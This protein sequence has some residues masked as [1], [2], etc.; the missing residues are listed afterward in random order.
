MSSSPGPSATGDSSDLSAT[1]SSAS[2]GTVTSPSA[3]ITSTAAEDP[4]TYPPMTT[5][6]STPLSCTWTYDIDHEYD[7]ITAGPIAYLDLEPVSDASTLTCYPDG[8]FFEGRTGTF[9]PATCPNGW[10]TVSVLQNTNEVASLATTTAVCCS[11][12]YSLD[13]SY[14]KREVPTALAV[15]IIYNTTADTYSIATAETSTLVSATLA[16]YPINAL[17]REED[18]E[19]L[20]LTYEEQIRTETLDNRGLSLGARI[21]I[22]IGATIGGLL[23]VG[24]ALWL[25]CG[26]RGKRECKRRCKSGEDAGTVVGA[27]ARGAGGDLPPPA[28]EFSQRNGAA[29]DDG[30]EVGPDGEIQVLKAQK[31]AIQRRIEELEQVDTNDHARVV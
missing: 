23:L 3:P 18:K 10:T 19:I 27:G 21:G 15:P 5:Q 13:G 26:K 1:T 7:P 30:L 8:M 2:P 6:W 29:D 31:A 28:Y 22:G 11:A 16:V 14:C 17:F 9:S 25:L 20:G 12:E 4:I 24:L